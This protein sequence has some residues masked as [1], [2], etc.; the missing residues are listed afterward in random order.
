MANRAVCHTR[1]DSRAI[2]STGQSIKRDYETLAP[3]SRQGGPWAGPYVYNQLRPGLVTFLVRL[4]PHEQAS[5][6]HFP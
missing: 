3:P 2:N 4:L 6:L 5:N 1:W